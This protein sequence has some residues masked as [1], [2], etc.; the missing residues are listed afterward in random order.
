MILLLFF[1]PEV[2]SNSLKIHGLQQAR[3]PYYTNELSLRLGFKAFP[4][5]CSV[6]VPT[7][8]LPFTLKW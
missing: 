5:V 1:S 2:L 8:V 7:L 6:T 4:I 3:L